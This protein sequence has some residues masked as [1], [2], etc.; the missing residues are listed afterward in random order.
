M[1]RS[2]FVARKRHG[3]SSSRPAKTNQFTKTKVALVVSSCLLGSGLSHAQTSTDPTGERASGEVL[4]E[5]IVRGQRNALN[6]SLDIKRQSQQVMESITADDI[7]KMPDQNVT[8]SLQR[9]TGIQIDREGGEGTKVRIRGLDQNVTLLNGETFLTGLEYFQLGE[10]RVEFTN[11]LEGIPSELLGGV[12]VYKSPR[13]SLVEGGLGG[14]INLKTRSPFSI[15]T[16][17]L[18]LAGNA[19]LDQ[20]ADSSDAQPSG[21]VVLGK[22]WD[23][24]FGAILSIT[25]NNKTV[26]SDQAQTFSRQGF[27]VNTLPNGQDYIRPGM[28]YFTDA[29]TERERLGASLTLGWRPNDNWEL[30]ADW[31][32]A[33]LE[34][35]RSSYSVKHDMGVDGSAGLEAA[36][37]FVSGSRGA[38]ILTPDEFLA[39]GLV[40]H[41]FAGGSVA[42]IQ[43]GTFIAGGSETNTSREMSD[44]TTDNIRLGA[45]FDNGGRLTASFDLSHSKADY[46]SEYAFSDSRFS[47]YG[48]TT[49]T[50]QGETGWQVVANNDPTPNT[51]ADN[52]DDLRVWTY[53]TNGG[54]PDVRYADEGWLT[55]ARYLNFKS[56]WAFGDKVSNEE[57]A[58]RADLELDMDAG[59]LQTLRFGARVADEE[60]DF[61][62][63]HYLADLSRNGAPAT[64]DPSFDPGPGGVG[65]RATAGYDIGDVD[66]DGIS[67]AQLFGPYY[68]FL[69]AAIGDKCADA[70]TSAGNPLCEALYG[71]DFAR[72]GG[73]SPGVIPWETYSSNPNRAV[74]IND[75]FPTGNYQNGLL[76][77]DAARMGNPSEWFQG[78]AGGA[79]VDFIEDPLESWNASEQTT[80]AYFEA[81]FGG[82]EANWDLNIGVRVIRTETEITFSK[83]SP[84]TE[85]LWSTDTWNGAF[86]DANLETKKVSYTDVLPSVNFSYD[87]DDQRKIRV[88]AASVI[89]RPDLQLLGRGFTQDLTRDISC[90]CFRFNG[91]SAGNPDL[92]PFRADQFDLSYEW[93]FGDIG[94]AS[95]TFFYKDVE[96]FIASRTVQETQPDQ[97]PGGSSTAGVTRPFNG[98]G[99]TVQGLELSFQTGFDNGF[100]LAAN[101][102]YSDSETGLESLT[103][104]NLPLPGVSETSYNLIG[105]Y[106]NDV[107]QA[108]LAY[109]WRDEFLAP[110]NTT[111]GV[112]GLDLPLASWYR[113][114]GQWDASFTYNFSDTLALSAE[115]IN[116]TGEQQERYLEWSD[117][118]FTYD[119]QETRYILGVN[120]R[121]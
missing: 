117:N 69:D 80:A 39:P 73:G 89:A 72:F 68:R 15:G 119:S 1:T 38:G 101:F 20:G 14:T 48:V 95:A 2:Q 16:D 32:H 56:H 12:D 7:G 121:F 22:N 71:F 98:D 24:T 100:G 103:R 3:Q 66:G 49:Y 8:E 44:V 35:D 13:A 82:P 104:T 50:G 65:L 107:I 78:I 36:Y 63:G 47:P 61:V 74:R 77:D 106:E 111:I 64:F 6:R 17:E 81:D 97:T 102:T 109:T 53:S 83:A 19:K 42:H 62:Q 92:D 27:Q 86:R 54:L 10:A 23:D 40:N 70:V 57:T 88:N 59:H 118:F 116:I 94:L 99:G 84:A 75:Y 120:F 87:L 67:D 26:H 45:E 58:L 33:G 110:T 21:A 9:L 4:E 46:E 79:P 30:T 91:G 31:T 96:S 93:Y 11:S 18:L 34:L 113:D 90:N 114:Y 60:V 51:G 5:I 52:T 28:L 55:D 112:G 108:R 76:F 43:Q 105:F 29:E 41:N 25:T 85:R 37:P 115:V